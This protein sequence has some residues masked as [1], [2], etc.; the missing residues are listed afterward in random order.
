MCC[1]LAHRFSS[2]VYADSAPF[3]VGQPCEYVNCGLHGQCEDGVCHCHHGWSGAG[4]TV[5]YCVNCDAA[6]S[7]CDSTAH[8]AECACA[9]GWVGET[10]HTPAACANNCKHGS[11]RSGS[12]DACGTCQW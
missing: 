9:E 10:C 5:T 12:S 4:C 8:H 6:H 7:T 1:V 11:V 2:G 3:A